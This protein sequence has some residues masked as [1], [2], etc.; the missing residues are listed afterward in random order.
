MGIDML[1]TLV[2]KIH[3]RTKNVLVKL[4]ASAISVSL[5]QSRQAK[6]KLRTLSTKMATM[7]AGTSQH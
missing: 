7:S 6:D 1:S 5:I 3:L 4:S 2:L